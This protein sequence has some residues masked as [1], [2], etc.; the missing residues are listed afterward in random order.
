MTKKIHTLS[1]CAVLRRLS[2]ML[3]VAACV[4][5]MQAASVTT[6][7]HQNGKYRSEPGDNNQQAVHEDLNVIYANSGASLY[8]YRLSTAWKS[9][10]RWYD[11]TTDAKMDGLTVS[12]FT[13]DGNYG[14]FS[15]SSSRGV[16]NFTA[17][18]AYPGG[19]K[20]VGCDQSAF[21]DYTPRNNSNNNVDFTEPTLSQRQIFD[22]RP[23]A[24]MADTVD[25]FAVGSDNWLET[26]KMTAPV[27][28][29]I[30]IGPKYGYTTGANY[31]NYFFNSSFPVQMLEAM[32]A[33][34]VYVVNGKQYTSEPSATSDDFSR[35]T[36]YTVT[37]ITKTA[38]TGWHWSTRSENNIVN[39]QYASFTRSTRDGA[40]TVTYTLVYNAGG[41]KVET[42][43]WKTSDAKQS[44][45]KWTKDAFT[46]QSDV[47]A[48]TYNIAKFEVEYKAVTEVGPALLGDVAG[49]DTTFLKSAKILAHQDFNYNVPGTTELR[50]LDTPLSVEEST[51]GFFYENIDHNPGGASG[52]DFPNYN[53]YCF[54]NNGNGYQADQIIFANHK[55]TFTV[56]EEGDTTFNGF[57]TDPKAGY[58]LYADGSSKPGTVFSINFETTLCPGSKMYFSAFIGELGGTTRP[59]LDFIVLGVD[60]NGEETTLTTF[61]TGEFSD[62]TGGWRRILFPLDYNSNVDFKNYRLR[63]VN[64]AKD[65][66]G[67]DFFIDDVFI[68]LMPSAI[69]PVQAATPNECLTDQSPLVMYTRLDYAQMLRTPS[70]GTTDYYYRWVDKKLADN[71]VA[72]PAHVVPTAYCGTSATTYGKVTVPN[73]FDNIT[74]SDYTI[75]NGTF[76]QFQDHVNDQLKTDPTAF[77]PQVVYI[78]ENGLKG[79]TP[80]DRY[81]AYIVTKMAKINGA[82][83]NYYTCEVA[84]SQQE[85]GTAG[86][87]ATRKGSDVA[88]GVGISSSVDGSV[89]GQQKPVCANFA[90]DLTYKVNFAYI[91]NGKV[92]QDSSAYVSHWLFGNKAAVEATPALYGNYTFEQ[93]QEALENYKPSAPATDPNTIIV[94]RLINN[95]VLTLCQYGTGADVD[96]VLET[97]SN[98]TYVVM[99]I[100]GEKSLTFTAFPVARIHPKAPSCTLPQSITLEFKGNGEGD[101]D[102][103]HRDVMTFVK[104]YTEKVPAFVATRPR[105]VRVPYYTY[106]ASG[107]RAQVDSKAVLV[108]LSNPEKEYI[109]GEKIYLYSTDDKDLTPSATA[110]F[111]AVTISADKQI[112]QTSET[113]PVAITFTGLSNL[114]EGHTY[115]FKVLYTPKTEGENATQEEIDAYCGGA[116]PNDPTKLR[117]GEAYITFIMVPDLINYVGQEN[118][119]WNDDYSYAFTSDGKTYYVAPSEYTSVVFAQGNHI[120]CNPVVIEGEKDIQEKGEDRAVDSKALPYITYDIDY[121]P[122]TARNIYVPANTAVVGHANIKEQGTYTFDMPV[123]AGKW[124]MTAMPVQG[125]VSGDIFVPADGEGDINYENGKFVV[126]GIKQVG[127]TEAVDREKYSFYNSLFNKEVYNA[128]QSGS[129]ID[130]KYYDITT[131]TWS[132]ATNS[133]NT[134]FGAGYGWALGYDAPATADAVVMRLPKNESEYHYFRNDT[135]LELKE[136]RLNREGTLGKPAF[137]GNTTLTLENNEAGNVFVLGNPTFAYIDLTKL[138]DANDNITGTFYLSG[139]DNGSRYDHVTGQA[140]ADAWYTT[141]GKAAQYLAPM[142]AVLVVKSGEAATSLDIQLNADMLVTENG[143]QEG[144]IKDA[145]AEGDEAPASAP[146]RVMAAQDKMIYIAAETA[147][148]SSTALLVESELAS[149]EALQG[150]DAEAFLL[151]QAKT[152]FAVYTVADGKALAINRIADQTI[153][154]LG[155]FAQKTVLSEELSFSGADSYLAEWDLVDNQTGIREPLSDGFT[156]TL[157]MNN[158]G[159]IR[160]YL[161]HTRKG[162]SGQATGND[163]ISNSLNAYTRDGQLTVYSADDMTDF[164]LYDAAGRTIA[165]SKNAGRMA[166]FNLANG[167]YVVRTSGDVL[168][169]IVK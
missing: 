46:T 31:P 43:T 140:L 129:G 68:Y 6:F 91:D 41:V 157:S 64:K 169:V 122:Y 76:A 144:E 116:D 42:A 24:W 99:P 168:K 152:P 147:S 103:V 51:F 164:C 158:A 160:Y 136:A 148:F 150:E 40:G 135:W 10:A 26:Y 146:R 50:R 63:V 82:Y 29:R 33:S 11:Y 48:K 72:T 166:Q 132:F 28:R 167:V 131:S 123:T 5:S 133:L 53:E 39:G 100:A 7:H 93:I 94:N 151:D 79:A 89:K 45:R 14:Y 69:E 4:A 86:K 114:K 30:Y 61:T 67:N 141:D 145:A 27:G 1:E 125:I 44:S 73:Q 80:E 137:T 78:K 161:E 83:S 111:E 90:Y 159:T 163:A 108:N 155:F 143:S 81:V 58:A 105:R 18:Y 52:Y 38:G 109:L 65:N 128:E 37:K 117:P 106:N 71:E 16:G 15:C 121:N 2:M 118:G 32:T 127:G 113:N 66:A 19:H 21:Y 25:R 3:M 59:I 142:H 101:E 70:G 134:S 23:A 20:L 56:S 60:D 96:K 115:T 110:P 149:D 98:I 54:V 107:V 92:V 87:C 112:T 22:V 49:S 97:E 8:L 156:T 153:V 13:Y 75:F 165:T 154:P 124:T 162:I 88:F 74:G 17:S 55:T 138:A 36:T 9:Y 126:K 35:N 139:L 12:N 130:N 85:L 95:G 62:C 34:T 47:A 102:I 84:N 77:V 104:S 57:G 120:L 119:S